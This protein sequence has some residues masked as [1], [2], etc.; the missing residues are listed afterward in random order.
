MRHLVAIALMTGLAVACSV[1]VDITNKVCPCGDGYQCINEVCVPPGAAAV[2]DPCPCETSAEC[3]DK[4]RPFCSLAAKQCVEC[5]PTPANDK[6]PAGTFCNAQNQCI[7]GC[8]SNDDCARLSPT[9]PTCALDRHQC[10]QCV[11]RADCPGTQTCTENGLCAESCGPAKECANGTCCDGL[12]FDTQT[13]AFNC[14]ACDLR[15]ASLNAATKCTAGKC[16]WTCAR[17]FGHCKTENTGCETNIG[18]DA[19]NCGSCTNVCAVQNAQQI[20]AGGACNFTA[21]NAGFEDRDGDRSNGCEPVC[22]R[23]DEACCQR[24][25]ECIGTL[26]CK[27]GGPNRRCQ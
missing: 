3:T 13:D 1:D 4:A 8:R 23:K 18:M 5:D 25:A 2:C 15:C 22:G 20:C 14:G 9:N 11:T 27:G 19:N 12:C 7:V 26:T 24:G 16:E 10:V 21:C 6:C 17:G